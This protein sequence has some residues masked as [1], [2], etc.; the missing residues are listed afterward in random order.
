MALRAKGYRLR[1]VVT[2]LRQDYGPALAAVFPQAQHHEC[3]FHAGKALHRQ[4]W[5]S[6]G[7]E[8]YWTDQQV[9]ALR[10]MVDGVLAAETKRTSQR[11]YDE[12]MAQQQALVADQPAVASVFATLEA[13]WPTLINGIESDVIPR[14]NNTVEL[15]IRRFDQHYQNM[16][17]FDSVETA[18]VFLGVFKKV[19]RFT[20]FSPDA[21]PRLRGKSPLQLAGYD[22]ETTLGAAD[23]AWADDQE[24]TLRLLVAGDYLTAWVNGAPIFAVADA[25]QPL[26]GGA[27]ALICDGGDDGRGRCGRAPGIE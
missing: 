13:H 1:V 21:Q 14:T 19:Y 17:G 6:Y 2:N 25:Q 11:R 20:P 23:L 7:R 22:V 12:V 26:T 5:D 24:Y 18:S 3:L 9:V 16:C 8:R 15:V 10:R 27:M 4:L